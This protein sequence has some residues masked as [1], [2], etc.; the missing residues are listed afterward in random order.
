MS[1]ETKEHSEAKIRCMFVY[2]ERDCKGRQRRV[3]FSE[4]NVNSNLH[5][6]LDDDDGIGGDETH[7]NDDEQ[8]LQPVTAESAEQ[9]FADDG[10]QID[11]AAADEEDDSVAREQAASK[12]QAIQRGRAVRK[13]MNAKSS[14]DTNDDAL[15]EDGAEPTLA[16][17]GNQ[18]DAAAADEEGDSVAR[19][20][21]ASK[22]QAIQRGRAVRKNM[23]AKSSGDTNDDALN[24]DGAEPAL[25]DEGN[26]IDAAAA[27]EE[28]DSVAREQAASKIQ[29][30][31]RGR[32]VRK[33]MNAKSSGDT[34]DDA[35]N[36]GWCR[37]NTCR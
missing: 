30:I 18:I 21:A 25:S 6:M 15:N 28:D 34:N 11:A 7:K 36:G 4:K 20:Q 10:N 27:D 13:N 23:N 9:S 14:G 26:Q 2:P 22:I 8:Q 5:P 33:N 37:A 12:I 32:A 1:K 17:E 29:A 19:E 31:Q 3:N 16:D 24:E 35:L